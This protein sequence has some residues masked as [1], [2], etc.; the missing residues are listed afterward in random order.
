[1]N[2]KI[3]FWLL[4]ILISV[5][6]IGTASA[7][8]CYNFAPNVIGTC[9][10]S[11]GNNSPVITSSGGPNAVTTF[12][13]SENYHISSITNLHITPL[14]P[15]GKP[16]G[17]LYLTLTNTSTG[18]VTD[19]LYYDPDAEVTAGVMINWTAKLDIDLGPGTYIISDGAPTT[20]AYNSGPGFSVVKGYLLPTTITVTPDPIA[21]YVNEQTTFTASSKD[22][23]GNALTAMI[24]WSSNNTTVGTI[25]STTGIFT[26]L[27]AGITTITATNGT[28]SG[29]ATVTVTAPS[30][31]IPPVLTTIMITPDGAE[32]YVGAQT[33]FTAS[34]ID[35]YGESF[36]ATVIWR[37]SN[38]T[39]GTI[40]STG[41]FTALAPGTTTITAA[42]GDISG[43]ASVT[44]LSPLCDQDEEHEHEHDNESGGENH[45]DDTES[46]TDTNEH[47]HEDVGDD[48]ADDNESHTNTHEHDNESVGEY[49]EDDN[50]SHTDAHEHDN[51]SVGEDHEDDNESHTDTH[52]HD[53]E[54]V[55]EDHEDDIKTHDVNKVKGS[56]DKNNSDKNNK[57]NSDKDNKKNGGKK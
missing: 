45:A 52:E 39:V 44:V 10:F 23:S 38:E 53:N 12:T 19:P 21:V 18:I 17:S 42:N 29:T 4:L 56:D 11:S 1:M 13:I 48:H 40:D 33:I 35:Q 8:E 28:I 27:A 41:M 26:A 34:T 2:T 54:S 24:A 16:H 50:E 46:H 7:A 37:S 51:E 49:R 5:V 20:W 47:D 31:I 9:I 57:N 30:T 3:K 55:G 22:R 32:G 14:S 36:T 6:S 15:R 25:D 43:I